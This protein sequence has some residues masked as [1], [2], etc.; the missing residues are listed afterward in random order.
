M[1]S[2][3]WDEVAA[4]LSA[5][6]R[7]LIFSHVGPD[8]DAFG[9]ALGLMWLLRAQG[10]AAEVSFEDPL[11]DTFRFLP[12]SE[13]VADR[14][15]GDHDLLVAVDGSDGERYGRH[16][17]AALHDPAR[18]PVICIDHHKTNTRFAD[19]NWVD[20]QFAATA[21]MIYHLAVQ[22]GWPINAEAATCLATGCVTDTNAFSTDHTTPAV[23]EAVADLMRH[24]ASLGEI[25]RY[26]MH[27]RS[28]ADALLWG[29][30]LSTLQIEEGVAWAVSRQADR[31]ALDASESDGSGISNFLRNIVGVGIGILFTEVEPSLVRVS[32]RSLPAYD[33]SHV[34]LAFG[35]GG[36]AQASGATLTLPLDEAIEQVVQ[37]AQAVVR[38]T[39]P[40]SALPA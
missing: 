6:R 17:S 3:S 18:P 11:L 31:Q 32:L 26:G 30:I 23:L 16:F 28:A 19:V 25:V 9:S 24:G 22:G 21:H 33:V 38:S 13:Q 39:P 8:G 2:A 36:H 1:S 12:G 20:S 4:H 29:R 10:K 14:P 15:M 37:A 27:L 40:A 34:A 7:P 5:A 35:G